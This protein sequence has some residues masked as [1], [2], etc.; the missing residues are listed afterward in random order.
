MKNDYDKVIMIYGNGS[1]NWEVAYLR[2]GENKT[3]F[4]NFPCTIIS[5]KSYYYFYF[6]DYS[7]ESRDL[8]M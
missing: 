1:G 5:C 7:E 2:N 8:E 6:I 4:S 3:L